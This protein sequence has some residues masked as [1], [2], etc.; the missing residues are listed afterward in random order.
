VWPQVKDRWPIGWVLEADGGRLVGSIANIPSLYTFRGRDLLCANGGAWVTAADYRPF[1]PWLMDEYFSQHDVDLFMNTT[2]GKLAT[3]IL[4]ALST[5]IPMG[6]W[7]TIAYWITGYRGFAK[8]ALDKMR[9]PLPASLAYPAAAALRVKDALFL[10][11]I[12]DAPPSIEV[13]SIDRFDSRFDAFWAEL[14]RQNPDKLLAYRDSAALSW[15]FG[16]GLRSDRV[17]IFTASTGGLLRAFCVIRR[18]D[19]LQAVKRMRIVDYQTVDGERDL[20]PALLKA[21]LRHCAAQGIHLLDHLGRQIP[22]TQSIDRYAPY[23]YKLLYW[24][25]YCHA[26]DPAVNDQL[27]DPQVWDPSSFDGDASF[28]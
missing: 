15:H 1:A 19:R 22:K 2:V 4:S 12:P 18:Q 25:Y 14:V 10:K 24:P 13:A 16:V 28:G 11:A 6:E 20:L 5:R 3:P 21:A 26:P 17:R 7:Q 27:R 9:I 8:K 23:R